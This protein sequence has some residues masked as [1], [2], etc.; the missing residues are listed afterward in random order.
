[1]VLRKGKGRKR[2]AFEVIVKDGR[3]WMTRA[4]IVSIRHRGAEQGVEAHDNAWR[5]ADLHQLNV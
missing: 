1:M 4:K 3:D 5:R 2:V